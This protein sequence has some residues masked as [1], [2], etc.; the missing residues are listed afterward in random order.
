MLWRA[1]LRAGRAVPVFSMRAAFP[2]LIGLLV[3]PVVARADPAACLAAIA[4][5]ERTQDLPPGLLGAIATAESGRRLPGAP[6]AEPWPW[7]INIAGES[8]YADSRAEAVAQV[9]A[10]RA[11]GVRQVDVG[12]MQ[13]SLAHHPAAFATLDEAFDPAANVAYGARFLTELR[14]RSA[15]WP[16]AIGRYHSGTP[17]RAA[18]YQERVLALLE[19]RPPGFAAAVAPADRVSVMVAPAALSVRVVMPGGSRGGPAGNA[20]PGLPRIVTPTAR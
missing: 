14:A 3:A 9:L 4:T 13:I 12:C 6:R 20:P 8:R 10:A 17:E 18:A 11:Q 19:G 5:V 15:D 1:P 16:E 7:A 2:L